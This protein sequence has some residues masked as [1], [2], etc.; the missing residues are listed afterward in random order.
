MS[1]VFAARFHWAQEKYEARFNIHR[2]EQSANVYLFCS[3]FLFIM[4]TREHYLF[5]VEHL[6]QPTGK[7]DIHM[8]EMEGDVHEFL[9]SLVEIWNIWTEPTL[10]P[11]QHSSSVCIYCV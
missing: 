6:L 3:N 2:F 1:V 10:A 8:T 4:C 5:I 7:Y 11:S 9:F